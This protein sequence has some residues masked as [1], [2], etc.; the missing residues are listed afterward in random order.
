MIDPGLG[1]RPRLRS[2]LVVPSDLG[3][4]D[5]TDGQGRAKRRGDHDEQH[6]ADECDA[7]FFPEATLRKSAHEIVTVP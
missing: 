1:S 5:A 2:D 7:S 4:R 6:D 3:L